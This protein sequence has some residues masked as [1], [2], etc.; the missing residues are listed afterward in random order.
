MKDLL[1]KNKAV[2]LGHA[3]ADALGVPA[4]FADREK[5]DDKPITEMVGFGTYPMPAGCWSDD[6]SMSLAALDSLAQGKVDLDDV[7]KKF[8]AWYYKD[9]YTPTDEMFDA[10]GVCIAAI[11][12][13][14]SRHLPVTE[15]GLSGEQDNG[16]GSL[17]RIYPFVLYA[18]AKDFDRQDCLRLTDAASALTHAHERAKMGCGIYAYILLHLLETPD[19][20]AVYAALQEAAAHYGTHAEYVHYARLFRQDFAETP[21]DEIFSGGYVVHTL[22]AAVWCLLTTDNYRDC[23]CRAVNLGEDTDTVAAVAGSLAGLLY[24]RAAIP[25]EWLSLLKRRDYI[26]SLCEQ[27]TS[28]W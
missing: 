1:E 15:C 22:E 2:A 20:A 14:C 17:M 4:E 21:R 23:V 26:E 5:L 3:V 25:E 11:E 27:A 18:Y 16:N 12:N 6:T 8:G 10:G 7:M 19:R 24:G 13:Y 28:A 9:A